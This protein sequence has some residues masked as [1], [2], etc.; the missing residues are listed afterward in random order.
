MFAAD[1]SVSTN[2]IV[3]KLETERIADADDVIDRCGD[4]PTPA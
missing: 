2:S 3:N 4:K 1:S